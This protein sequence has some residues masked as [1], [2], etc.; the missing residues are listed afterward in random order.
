MQQS[1][2]I[3]ILFSK[4]SKIAISRASVKLTRSN[5][6]EHYKILNDNSVYS[7]CESN[8]KKQI[9]K[10]KKNPCKTLDKSHDRNTERASFTLTTNSNNNMNN[11]LSND[12]SNDKSQNSKSFDK[13]LG[14]NDSKE[15]SKS[16]L[17]SK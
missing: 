12:K 11:K 2:Y 3:L 10:T 7:S 17:K 13:N 5:V 1:W 14:K 16:I 6:L 9:A 8:D 15:N 4:L